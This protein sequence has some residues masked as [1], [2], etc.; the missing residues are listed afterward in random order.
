MTKSPELKDKLGL[1]NNKNLNL[2]DSYIEK[3]GY[4]K[5]LEFLNLSDHRYATDL[6]KKENK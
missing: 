3:K 2:S 4:P 6:N 1:I 5:D